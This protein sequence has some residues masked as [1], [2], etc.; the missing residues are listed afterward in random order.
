MIVSQIVAVSENW[1]IGKDNS[2]TWDMPDDMA[3]FKR[4]TMGHTVIMGRRNYEANGN[5]ALPGRSNIVI[6]RQKD[7]TYDDSLVFP[8]L[9]VALELC[10]KEGQEEVFIV[11]GGEIYRLSLPITD[12]IYL[13]VIHTK[14]EG[15]TT[16]PELDPSVWRKIH[17]DTHRADERNLYDYTFYILDRQKYESNENS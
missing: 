2:L 4:I 11:G 12:R 10:R 9:E 16:Y 3:W 17:I 6:S 8:N 1:I 13:T 14:L 5:M 15:D 7:L